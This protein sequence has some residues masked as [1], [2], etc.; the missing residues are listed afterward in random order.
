MLF[1]STAMTTLT[2][3]VVLSIAQSALAHT[4]HDAHTAGG[5]A[6]GFLHPI[7]GIDHLLAMVAV[8]LL[9]VRAG[10]RS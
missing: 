1:R 2:T 7:T 5:F 8:G 4:G 6:A 9:A 10:A 3:L